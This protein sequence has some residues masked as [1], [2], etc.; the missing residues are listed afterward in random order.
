MIEALRLGHPQPLEQ[1]QDQERRKPL[2]WRRRVVEGAGLQR[3]RQWLGNARLVSFEIARASPG[4]RCGQD[5]RRSRARHRRDRNRR[6]P[7]G[8]VARAWRQARSGAGRARL[9]RLSVEQERRGEARG[10]AP[11]PRASRPTGAPGC[12][13]PHSRRARDGSRLRAAAS[14]GSL[15]PSACAAS[16]ASIQPPTAPGTVNAASGPRGGISSWPCS[17]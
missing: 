4:C 7:R 11:A 17:R 8:R 10:P 1:R 12:G 6:A 9:G 5:R 13:S 15:P 14:S 16:S 3:Q 2:G